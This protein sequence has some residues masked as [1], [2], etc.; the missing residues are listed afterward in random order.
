MKV[1]VMRTDFAFVAVMMLA[2][3]LLMGV[4]LVGAAIL[5]PKKPSK[6]KLETY[7][8]GMETVGDAWVQF[9]VQYYIFALIFVL[10]DVGGVFLFPF[11]VAYN[12][13]PLYA[14]GIVCL[15]ILTLLGSLLYAWRKGVLQWD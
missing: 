12:S 5:R 9:R 1:V 3:V 15:F 14:V 2:A 6:A 4:A 10:F 7:E 11:A 13:L 8:C